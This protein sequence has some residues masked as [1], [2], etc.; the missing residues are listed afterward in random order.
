MAVR[1]LP[2][3][4]LRSGITAS[5]WSGYFGAYTIDEDARAVTHHVIGS[6]FPNLVGSNEIRYFRLERDRLVL[7]AD[8]AWGRV[9]IVWEKITEPEHQGQRG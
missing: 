4:N 8:T 9:N 5:A 6:W 7:D 1:K 2:L 3:R